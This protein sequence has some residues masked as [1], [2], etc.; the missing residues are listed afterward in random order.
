MNN[1]SAEGVSVR[2]V[3]IDPD[4]EGQRIDNY[5][6]ARLKGV[7]R[8][9]VYRLLRKGEVRVNKGRI[10]ASYRLCAGDT[11]RIPPV[12]VATPDSPPPAPGTSLLASLSAAILYED[13]Y[14]LV[15]N[16]PSGLASH[17]G[18]GIRHGA[19]EAMRSLRPDIRRLDLVHRL[20]RDTS[21][22][23]VFAKRRSSLRSLHEQLREHRV[24]KRYQLLVNGS[25]EGGRR[26]IEAP[27]DKNQL[28]SGER[29][30]RISDAGKPAMTEF[31]VIERFADATLLE[32]RPKTGRTHQIRV[33]AVAA[34]HPIAGDDKYGD[35]AANRTLRRVGL[36]RLFLHA[37]SMAFRLPGE[38]GEM[39][40]VTAPLS[41]DLKTVVA[42]LRQSATQGFGEK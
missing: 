35:D 34:G 20:D 24:D 5:L 19:I 32:A 1:P 38:D 36:R 13:D 16:K 10:Q 7:P 17:G 14:F 41:D 11:V 26:T 28:S 25:W 40:R 22:C 23:L 31:R 27:L 18:S 3:T 15:I 33:H 8:T 6:M 2:F 42:K 30:V 4:D 37:H 39:I 29:I 9:R 21:G 12:R